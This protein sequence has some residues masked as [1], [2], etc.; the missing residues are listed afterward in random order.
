[1]RR[2]PSISTVKALFAVSGNTCSYRK[3]EELLTDRTWN[4]VNAD[5]AHICGDRPGTARFDASMSEGDR[6]SFENLILLCPNHH[7]L[8][9]RLE[10]DAHPVGLLRDMK[11]QHESRYIG[12]TNW[13]DDQ[14]LEHY[15]T[16]AL[17]QVAAVDSSLDDMRRLTG[18]LAKRAEA[19]EFNEL[20]DQEF[21]RRLFGRKY[22][23]DIVRAAIS[24]DA[25]F[26]T[27]D[28]V[29]RTTLPSSTVSRELHALEQAGLLRRTPTNVSRKAMWQVAAHD[30]WQSLA[31]LAGHTTDRSAPRPPG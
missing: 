11:E 31:S 29:N 28:I 9:D 2:Q 13:A 23:L 25:A 4:E 27:K 16:A 5:I 24:L 21:S 8:I 15:A 1:M 17:F 7:R 10:P 20:E 19:Q 6:V 26:T 22:F 14:A 30:Q 12:S 18:L 3:C